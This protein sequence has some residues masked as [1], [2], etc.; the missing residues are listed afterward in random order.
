MQREIIT[1]LR[2]VSRLVTV[3][4]DITPHPDGAQARRAA[5]ILRER[6][7]GILFTVNEWGI[8]KEG[9]LHE[10]LES[11]RIL[12]VNWCVDDP[13]YEEV[14]RE[15]KF[16]SSP[17]RID[18]VSDRDY[19]AAMRKAGYH[20][21]FLP[22]GAD[23]GTFHPTGKPFERDCAFVGNSYTAQIEEFVE[24]SEN[25]LDS[26][27]PFLAKSL[28][29]YLRDASFDIGEAIESF[30][31]TLRLPKGVG[32]PKAAF[33][34]KHFAGYLFRKQTVGGLSAGITGFEL[35]GDDGWLTAARGTKL[36]KVRYG[37]GLRDV[38]TTTRVNI[39]LNR[40]VIRSGFTQRVFD[41]LAAGSFL[42]TNAK[43]IV[44]EFFTEGGTEPEIV[45]FRSAE[46][47]GDLVRYYCRNDKEREAIAKR[48]MR[49]VLGNHTYDHRIG[50][51]FRVVA[52]ELDITVR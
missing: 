37:E 41:A 35:F 30:I 10:Y 32:R 36:C 28:K 17:L 7:C 42:V 12:H 47:L 25:L 8:D 22:L 40:V 43:P 39:D 13:F 51:L 31:A 1:A 9:I 44:S 46:E 21:F 45:T 14:M 49:K 16:R 38:Y 29:R 2:R 19:V 48:G 4:L 6:N 3:V 50:E 24:G 27:A 15:K 11:E 52:R 33:I 20:A 34:A 18:F 26:M 5:E 23:P